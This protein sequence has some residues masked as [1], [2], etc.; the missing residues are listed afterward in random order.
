MHGPGQAVA[1]AATGSGGPP[2]PVCAGI[3][4]DPA[5]RYRVLAVVAVVA[6]VAVAGLISWN[7]FPHSVNAAARQPSL[8]AQPSAGGHASPGAR[9]PASD[10]AA[11]HGSTPGSAI[12]GAAGSPGNAAGGT[13]ASSTRQGT[14]S[15]GAKDGSG[16]ADGGSTGRSGGQTGGGSGSGSTPA[17]AGYRWLSVP[18]ATAGTAAGFKIAVPDTWSVTTQ[19]Q[20]TY[21]DSPAGSAYMEFNLAPFSYS[22][23]VREARF[24]QAQAIQQDEYPGYKVVAISPA[25]FRNVVAATWRFNWRQRSLGHVAVLELLF[26]LETTAG[27]QNYALSV[28]AP[29]LGFPAAR[30]AFDEVLHTF[31]RL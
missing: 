29:A 14:A 5:R 10:Q 25:A 17:P 30:T 3:V 21:V 26:S 4:R 7:A 6:V 20:V 9:A 13:T 27:P 2:Q 23:P 24:L 16:T 11:K 19:G 8:S 18:A 31:R 12:S 15:A 1:P 22:R 28:S